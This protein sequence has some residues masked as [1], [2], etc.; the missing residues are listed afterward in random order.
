ML[1]LSRLRQR[2]YDSFLFNRKPLNLYFSMIEEIVLSLF[3]KSYE[4]FSHEFEDMPEREF[5][6]LSL[7]HDLSKIEKVIVVGAG[8]I[9]YTAIFFSQ[10]IGKPVFAIEKNA[11]AYFACLRLLRRLRI[12]AIKVV[13]GSGQLYCNYGH[14]LVIITLHTLTKQMVLERVISNDE[15]GQIVVIR[16]PSTQNMRLFESASLE[17]LKYATIEHKKEGAYSFV[18]S[19]QFQPNT[20]IPNSQKS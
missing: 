18:I 3:V 7:H 17:G 5:A 13:K 16:Q 2:L 11:L 14:S 20:R 15:C 1:S 19:N 4:H 8:A 9:P 12:D 6:Y 10:K